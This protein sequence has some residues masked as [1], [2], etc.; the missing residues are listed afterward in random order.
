MKFSKVLPLLFNTLKK[1]KVDFAL[2]GGIALHTYGLGRTTMDADFMILL[3]SAESVDRLMKSL[4]Y[5]LMNQTKTFANYVAKDPDLG[6]VDFMYAGK[7]ISI[8]M[9]K[10]A[11]EQWLLGEMV[12]VLQIEDLIGLKVLSSSNDPTRASKDVADI[13]DLMRRHFRNLNWT[14]VKSY[15]TMF[16]RQAEFTQLRKRAR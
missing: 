11:K 10:R 3:S 9:L 4:G 5:K 8:G 16:G 14:L 12:K 6:R 2:I 1:Q 13:E 15:F 7:E